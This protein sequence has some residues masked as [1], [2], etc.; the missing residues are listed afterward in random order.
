MKKI[1][2][3]AE[4]FCN[5]H[6]ATGIIERVFWEGLSRREY[7]IIV[8]CA[9]P[10]DGV[11]ANVKTIYKNIKPL[12]TFIKGIKHL[13]PDLGDLPDIVYFNNTKRQI[14]D[15]LSN[16]QVDCIQS[17]NMP[18]SDHLLAYQIKKETGLPWIAQLYDPWVDNSFRN[19]RFQYFKNKD[20]KLEKR[21]AEKAD[22][23]I[24]NN[25]RLANIWRERYGCNIAKKI[26]VL[27]LVLDTQ[28]ITN[29]HSRA[30][31]NNSL[32]I[33][34]IGNFY[35]SR[36]SVCFIDALKLVVQ[37]H[38]EISE[39]MKINFV[40]TITNCD[41]KAIRLSGLE[42]MFNITGLIPQEECNK[43]YQ[44]SDIFLSIDSMVGDNFFFPS[45]LLKYFYYNK[46]ILGLSPKNSATVDELSKSGHKF[47][48]GGET[49]Q[50]AEY[51]EL[52]YYHYDRLL[53]FD[54]EYYKKFDM[55]TVLSAYENN[56]INKLL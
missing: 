49:T 36:N 28:G 50:I 11:V 31:E 39:G 22:V 30:K 19:F 2:L 21:L 46:P 20:E 37:K 32:I 13:C 38:P 34:H 47:F 1:L 6:S 40:G 23:I 17:I 43:Y 5:I 29:M 41:L 27:P 35:L 16:H 44:N 52:A 42:K 55:E 53:N 45:K 14:L 3:I 33:S 7:E 10:G 56:I 54:H 9:N 12:R 8:F 26:E 25:N 48:D 51:L 18:L 4:P 15:Y 24:H